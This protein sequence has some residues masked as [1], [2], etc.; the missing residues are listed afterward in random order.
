MDLSRF[1]GGLVLWLNIVLCVL[2]LQFLPYV[3]FQHNFG[4]RTNHLNET[5]QIKTL[6]PRT[7][8]VA[9]PGWMKFP[10][11]VVYNHDSMS[12]FAKL[13]G[14]VKFF[15][16]FYVRSDDYLVTMAH[17]NF[18]LASFAFVNIRDIRDY[19]KPMVEVKVDDYF[20]QYVA[21]N[22]DEV[23]RF[24]KSKIEHPN[25]NMTFDKKARDN[26][27][28]I[29]ISANVNSKVL[30]C[31]FRADMGGLEG[32][33]GIIQNQ[34]DKSKHTLNTKI[35][36]IRFEGTLSYNGETILN[37]ESGNPCLGLHDNSRAYASY[38]GRWIWPTAVFKDDNNNSVAINLGYT[39]DDTNSAFD[40]VFINGKM[41]KLDAHV[42]REVNKGLYV[43]D[44]HP[45][46]NEHSEATLQLEFQTEATHRLGDNLV[47]LK[48][49]LLSSYGKFSGR[50][51]TKDGHDI[52]FT[53]KF[54]FF[55][56]MHSLW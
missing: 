46:H 1:L 33:T 9:T 43:W 29:Q 17:C 30:T 6:D 16:Y 49:C 23:G 28:D 18:G 48:V 52:K 8:A 41:Y 4:S 47:L 53:N 40:W 5:E 13:F 25:F 39:H 26:H 56:D 11:N 51:V 7:G 3:P 2:Y 20:H 35:P 27:A 38:V 24:I 14:R 54:G 12:A 22:V 36:S 45:L 42:M 50:I 32:I 44:K 31:K 21:L 34:Q 55:E 10:N 19:S 15:N 37:C